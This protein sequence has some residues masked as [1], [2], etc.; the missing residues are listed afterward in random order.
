MVEWT[1]LL[2]HTKIQAL[3]SSGCL[4]AAHGV[5][6]EDLETDSPHIHRPT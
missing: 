4:T 5:S 1:D 6:K 3:D 2:H